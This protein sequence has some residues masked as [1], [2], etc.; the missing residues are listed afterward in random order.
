MKNSIPEDISSMVKFTFIIIKTFIKKV[1]I[2][3]EDYLLPRLL[4]TR[5]LYKGG[6]EA[7]MYK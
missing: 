1:V 2:K 4:K 6:R 3:Q 5:E 7:N